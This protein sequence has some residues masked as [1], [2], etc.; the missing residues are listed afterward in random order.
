MTFKMPL[1]IIILKNQ[2]S[3]NDFSMKVDKFPYMIHYRIL[4]N[5]KQLA[6]K[7]F[8][9]LTKTLINGKIELRNNETVN[10]AKP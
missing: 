8:S 7:Q 4:K 5:Q 9:V 1:I 10:Q 3:E 2:S 6:L